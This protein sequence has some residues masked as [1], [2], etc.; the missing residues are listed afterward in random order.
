MIIHHQKDDQKPS[1]NTKIYIY[2]KVNT[3]NSFIIRSEFDHSFVNTLF[4]YF[5]MYL[6]NA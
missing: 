5:F 2:F 6:R 3:F 1:Y 4:S